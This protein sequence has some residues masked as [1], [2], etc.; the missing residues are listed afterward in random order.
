MTRPF[1]ITG[2]EPYAGGGINP[3]YE[4]MKKVSGKIIYNTP[5]VGYGLPVSRELMRSKM[6][7][8]IE[9]LNPVGIIGIGLWP[10][11]PIIRIE[12][13][14]TN[15]AD[16]EIPDNQG[17]RVR[18]ERVSQNALSA[19]ETTLP[20]HKI[21]AGLLSKGIPARLSSTAGTFLCNAYLFSIM[22]IIFSS[23][24]IIPAG[25][26][27]VPYLPEQ[28]AELLKSIQSDMTTELHQRF[29]LASMDLHMMTNAIEFAIKTSLKY[30]S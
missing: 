9:Q 12:R 18:N 16:Y 15:I 5:V 13:I 24:N 25:F 17:I 7:D 2:F 21:E 4:I 27:H 30:V 22:E 14:G 19:Y 28:V 1:L 11:E 20:I 23:G 8:I 3:A 10:G 26:I 29:D 6:K